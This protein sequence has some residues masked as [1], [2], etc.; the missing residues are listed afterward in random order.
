MQAWQALP[1]SW[2]GEQAVQVLSPSQVVLVTRKA[3]SVPK[4]G[5]R[6]G[7]VGTQ[8]KAGSA[9]IQPGRSAGSAD[10]QSQAS[11]VS[12]QA[13]SIRSPSR[14]GVQAVQ[15]LLLRKTRVSVPARVLLAL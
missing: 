8:S 5:R 13:D 7:S 1:P 10:A 3:G 15:A 6:A 2:E 14:E 12:T 9:S 11:S 4:L